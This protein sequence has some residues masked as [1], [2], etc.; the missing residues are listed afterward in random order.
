MG[1]SRSKK[2]A[3]HLQ[4]ARDALAKAFLKWRERNG[5]SQQN[6]HEWARDKGSNGPHNSQVAFLERGQLDPKQEFWEALET[7]NKAIGDPKE[8]F[9]YV[10]S[11]VVRDRLQKATPFLTKSGDIAGLMDFLGYFYGRAELN[12]LYTTDEKLTS[13]FIAEYFK[14]TSK[15]FEDAARENVM[16]KKEAWKFIVET[17]PMKAIKEKELIELG[18]DALR[19]EALPTVDQCK[20]VMSKYKDCPLCVAVLL[21]LD[22]PLPKLEK[23]HEKMKTLAI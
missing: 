23:L 3:P 17:E 20:Y 19:G 8:K 12:S 6:I 22:H 10:T 13:D 14:V 2:V 4:E 1:V 21:L 18:L 11:E 15:A 5:L 16:S 7:L 9:I